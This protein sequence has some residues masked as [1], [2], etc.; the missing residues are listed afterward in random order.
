MFKPGL[1]PALRELSSAAEFFDDSPVG[2]GAGR[3]RKDAS[4][5]IFWPMSLREAHPAQGE[6]ASGRCPPTSLSDL[7]TIDTAAHMTPASSQWL[8]FLYTGQFSPSS[9]SSTGLRLRVRLRGCLGGAGACCVSRALAIGLAFGEWCASLPGCR[10]QSCDRA[11]GRTL[12][13]WSGM[14][15]G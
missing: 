5:C 8:W 4:G 12:Y 2:L 3:P 15:V 1:H 6:R 11:A 14:R 10:L 7:L 13:Y 9:T